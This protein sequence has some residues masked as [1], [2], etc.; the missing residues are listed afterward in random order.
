MSNDGRDERDNMDESLTDGG[1]T[2]RAEGNCAERAGGG[3][4]SSGASP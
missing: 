4:R 2:G 3:E 1:K